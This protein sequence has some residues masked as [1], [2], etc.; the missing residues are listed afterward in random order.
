MFGV[1]F[2]DVLCVVLLIVP[3]RNLRFQCKLSVSVYGISNSVYGSP[4]HIVGGPFSRRP[5]SRTNG[6]LHNNEL[7]MVAASAEA[8]AV[9]MQYKLCLNK[10]LKELNVKTGFS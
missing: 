3:L 6:K 5:I 2:L 7:P 9:T 8:Y 1:C 4:I 10:Y